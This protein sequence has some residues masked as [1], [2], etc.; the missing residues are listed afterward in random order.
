M[1]K[2]STKP[3]L[4]LYELGSLSE[5]FAEALL[6]VFNAPLD[7]TGRHVLDVNPVQTRAHYKLVGA[8]LDYQQDHGWETKWQMPILSALCDAYLLPKNGGLHHA[9]KI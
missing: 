7:A 8:F 1:A 3:E 2:A 5:E 6:A 4:P 9:E